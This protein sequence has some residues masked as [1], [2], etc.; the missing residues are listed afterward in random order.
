ME[1]A[2][3]K[4]EGSELAAQPQGNFK[5]E[6]NVSGSGNTINDVVL[7]QINI[8]N[9]AAGQLPPV[10]PAFCNIIVLKDHTFGGGCFTILE[11]RVHIA[12][13][14]ISDI[15]TYPTLFLSPNG[16][17]QKCAN[18]QQTFLYGRVTGAELKN[19]RYEVRYLIKPTHPLPQNKL[20][21]IAI[22]LGI[23]KGD[24]KDV[25]DTTGW[26]VLEIDIKTALANAGLNTNNP[27]DY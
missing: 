25:L 9:A 7:Q 19:N 6:I 24:G 21:K 11:Q 27:N 20:N 26:H 14:K 4:R 12:D 15:C 13:K 10:N 17:Y 16:A 8:Y 22:Q 23:N 3:A 18:P 5:S 2:L 1:S